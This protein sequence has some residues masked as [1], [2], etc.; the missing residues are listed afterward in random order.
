M[1]TVNRVSEFQDA[2]GRFIRREWAPPHVARMLGIDPDVE[3]DAQRLAAEQ[4]V[5]P[6]V[7]QYDREGRFMIMPFVEGLRL[8]ADWITRPARRVAMRE[9]LAR[10]RS[11]DASRLP[12]L[13]LPIRL[14]ELH[15]RLASRS[16]D[17]ASSYRFDVEWCIERL[18]AIKDDDSTLVH[19]DLTPENVIVRA[20]GSLCLID[21]E[22]AHRGHGDEDLAGLA[23]DAPRAGEWSLSPEAF[24]VRIRARRLLDGL[25]R[26]LATLLAD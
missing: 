3:V 12:R 24:P 18:E 25:W 2:R 21:W 16:A 17:Q 8:E 7:L 20:D 5:A 19:G 11:I 10:V 23:L 9:L 15:D 14:R 13:D 4:G 1:S 6:P 22:Y 26:E